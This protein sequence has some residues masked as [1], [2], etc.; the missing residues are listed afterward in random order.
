MSEPEQPPTDVGPGLPED[1][2]PGTG[3]DPREHSEHEVDQD[4]APQRARHTT[5][6]AP[7]RPEIRRPPEAMATSTVARADGSPARA[8]GQ[9]ARVRRFEG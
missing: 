2:Q 4:G 8:A 1:G 5:Q 9:T 3:I 7:R 6:T